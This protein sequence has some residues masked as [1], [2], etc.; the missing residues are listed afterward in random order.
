MILTTRIKK[1]QLIESIKFLIDN[2]SINCQPLCF[3]QL[4]HIERK[5]HFDIAAGEL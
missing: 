1:L 3:K 2:E 4:Q 5:F